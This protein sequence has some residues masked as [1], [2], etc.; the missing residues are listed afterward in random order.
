MIVA[1]KNKAVKMQ[2]VRRIEASVCWT[3]I[4]GVVLW[5]YGLYDIVIGFT[6]MLSVWLK[7]NVRLWIYY[8]LFGFR[9]VTGIWSDY[10]WRGWIY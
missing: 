8:M 4:S 5:E 9:E 6:D 3:V 7:Y 10:D 2:N 1:Q